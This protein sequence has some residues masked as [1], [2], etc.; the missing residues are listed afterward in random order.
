M[1]Y[2]WN[3][4]PQGWKH[5]PTICHGLIR[6]TLEKGEAPEHLQYID[7]IIVWGDT[8]EEV[9]EKGE[10]IIQILLRESK[11]SPKLGDSLGFRPIS[12][13]QMFTLAYFALIYGLQPHCI[14]FPAFFLRS[15][16]QAFLGAIGFWRMHI[17]DYSQIVNPLYLVTYKKNDFHW[18]PEQQLAFEQMKEEI[19]HTVALGPFSTGP[20]MKNLLYSAA[21]DNGPSWQKAPGE[22]RGCPFGF[23][24]RSYRGSETNNKPYREGDPYEGIQ[25]ASEVIGTEEQLLLTPQLPVLSWMFKGKMSSMHHATDVTW[26]KWIILITQCACT[27]NPNG[28]GILEIITNWLEDENFGLAGE[29]GEQV[30][31]AEKTPAYNKLPEEETCYALFTDGSCCIVGMKRKWKAAVWSSTQQVE[32]AT[33]GEG[34]LRQFAEL[35]TVQLALGIAEYE[36]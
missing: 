5:S 18:N 19:A 36:K 17:P 15:E 26:S 7:D 31:Q 24:S 32:E 28:P 22:T 21:R 27:G 8:A 6:A 35:K 29:E 2:T 16:P 14:M 3:R 25:A 9:F 10:K 1:Q 11:R 34:E 4:L 30:A 23:W 13:I 12:P 20:D 33:L